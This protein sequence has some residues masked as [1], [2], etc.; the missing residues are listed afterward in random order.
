M[1]DA[2]VDE[3]AEYVADELDLVYGDSN[4]SEI[5]LGEVSLGDDGIYIE[6]VPT[7][8]PDLYTPIRTF[9]IDFWA[10]YK[11]GET[12]Y[13][14]LKDIYGLLHQGIGYNLTSYQVY[15]SH[16]LGQIDDMA[17]DIEGRNIKRLTVKFTA[18]YL[19]S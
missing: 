7:E 3:L 1:S 9:T 17:R 19:L 16:A 12:A 2:F 5:R 10:R 11:S 6:S 15:F 4:D 8:E 13:L 18:R 14:K